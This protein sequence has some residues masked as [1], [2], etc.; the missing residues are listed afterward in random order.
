MTTRTQ[1]QEK[2]LEKQKRPFRDRHCI[3]TRRLCDAGQLRVPG[4]GG[5]VKPYDTRWKCALV[6]QLEELC[7][8]C[9]PKCRHWL[10]PLSRLE[11][12]VR[13]R[14]PRSGGIGP[15]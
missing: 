1:S 5:S 9:R 4:A 7:E 2:E 13:C 10:P 14:G 8:H 3:G 6:G 11:Q 12:S 15:A